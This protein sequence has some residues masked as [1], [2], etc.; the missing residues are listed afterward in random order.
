M[1]IKWDSHLYNSLPWEVTE[2]NSVPELNMGL[3]NFMTINDIFSREA[4]TVRE[5]VL[6]HSS[7]VG[8]PGLEASSIWEVW[9]QASWVLTLGGNCTK[10]EFSEVS[11]PR[12][13]IRAFILSFVV[14]SKRPFQSGAVEKD[15]TQNQIISQALKTI[16]LIYWMPPMCQVLCLEF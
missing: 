9:E 3:D 10:N 12:H 13:P 15:I 4:D 16:H 11:V 7:V 1:L 2:A 5:A 6:L 8:S 14:G